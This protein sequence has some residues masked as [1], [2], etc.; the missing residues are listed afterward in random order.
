MAKRKTTRT[1]DE[2]VAALDTLKLAQKEFEL[3]INKFKEIYEPST[4]EITGFIDDIESTIWDI[5]ADIDETFED[6]DD[7]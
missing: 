3:A 6:E 5:E 7:E 1:R 2:V 4:V